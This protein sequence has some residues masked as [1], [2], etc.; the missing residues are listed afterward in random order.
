MHLLLAVFC[1]F[2]FFGKEKTW[3]LQDRKKQQPSTKVHKTGFLYLRYTFALFCLWGPFLFSRGPWVFPTHCSVEFNLPPPSQTL[4]AE[5]KPRIDSMELPGKKVILEWRCATQ[6]LL[7]K[8]PGES[9]FPVINY[10][11]NCLKDSFG[12]MRGTRGHCISGLLSEPK[13]P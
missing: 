12:N 3:P 8:V 6:G 7:E 5:K 11:T 9:E 10:R 1:L 4:P 2:P 13:K